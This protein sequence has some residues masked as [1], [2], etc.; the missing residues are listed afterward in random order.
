MKGKRRSMNLIAVAAAVAFML[1]YSVPVIQNA[2]A[3]DDCA[4]QGGRYDAES[5]SCN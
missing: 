1:V 4:Q 3:V 5:K 2:A